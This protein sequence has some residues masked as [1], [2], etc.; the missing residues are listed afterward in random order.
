[1]WVRAAIEGDDVEA[2]ARG[3][4]R[5]GTVKVDDQGPFRLRELRYVR[6]LDRAT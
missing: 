5:D 4:V 2:A 3:W 1:M 6:A